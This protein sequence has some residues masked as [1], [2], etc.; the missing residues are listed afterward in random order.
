MK[1]E[2][3]WR[4]YEADESGIVVRRMLGAWVTLLQLCQFLVRAPT[5]LFTCEGPSSRFSAPNGARER[6]LELVKCTARESGSKAGT[7]RFSCSCR[8]HEARTFAGTPSS[9]WSLY[10]AHSSQQS[11]V[12]LPVV[13]V[14]QLVGC[15][16]HCLAGRESDACTL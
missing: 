4:R 1:T 9:Q 2:F 16:S 7:R 13:M 3:G 5:A 15:L 10:T 8:Q 14:G 11:T 6:C 12:W